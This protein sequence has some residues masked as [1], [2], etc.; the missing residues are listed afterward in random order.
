LDIVFPSPTLAR[1]SFGSNEALPV[2]FTTTLFF[3]L[4]QS[5]P[6]PGQRQWNVG[7]YSNSNSPSEELAWTGS[8]A[9]L[10]VA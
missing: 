1:K 4:N 3:F 7:N 6:F 2:F 9:L 5:A 8:G 10:N